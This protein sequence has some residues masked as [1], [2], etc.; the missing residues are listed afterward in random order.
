MAKPSV[1]PPG[2]LPKRIQPKTPP[3]QVVRIGRNDRCP[4]G[5]GKKFKD[6]H[7]PDGDAFL[8]KLAQEQQKRRAKEER[9]RLKAAGVPWY[10]RILVR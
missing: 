3:R 5:S 10:K 6:C 8:Q 9:D 2:Q 7:E 1:K 4:C